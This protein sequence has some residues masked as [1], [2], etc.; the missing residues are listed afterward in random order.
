MASAGKP[1]WLISGPSCPEAKAALN[2]LNACEL[3]SRV[4][5]TKQ[6]ALGFSSTTWLQCNNNMRQQFGDA[7]TPC[8]S[9][10][11]TRPT[12]KQPLSLTEHRQHCTWARLRHAS[13][14]QALCF[15]IRKCLLFISCCQWARGNK[16]CYTKQH[17]VTS[18]QLQTFFL[19]SGI[20]HIGKFQ[21]VLVEVG[22]ADLIW[23][24]V[25]KWTGLELS[26]GFYRIKKESSA[27][28]I[29]I[30]SLLCVH[31]SNSTLKRLLTV[32][33]L[34]GSNEFAATLLPIARKCFK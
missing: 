5:K 28:N 6:C 25:F 21:S 22:P 17:N 29:S 26:T 7:S 14:P 11:T 19:A 1:N 30:S 12:W 3:E 9:T 31:F 18:C 8:C 32:H 10:L 16:L 23:Q 15:V 34:T 27:I 2:M 24:S 33:S 4:S 13:T 20:L